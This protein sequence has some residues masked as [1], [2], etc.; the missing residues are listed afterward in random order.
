MSIVSGCH[1]PNVVKLG[2]PQILKFVQT[3]D[4]AILYMTKFKE[5]FYEIK[6]AAEKQYVGW[7]KMKEYLKQWVRS[8]AKSPWVTTYATILPLFVFDSHHQ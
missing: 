5:D 6:S 1:D 2:I 7:H 8:I 3:G 4:S